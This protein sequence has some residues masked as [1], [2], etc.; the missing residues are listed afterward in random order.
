MIHTAHRTA[1][2]R[3][4]ASE[5]RYGPNTL[6]AYERDLDDFSSY[7][8]S[9]RIA[10]DEPLSRQL[11]RG[12]LAQM[13]SRKLARTT[14]ARR[15]SSLRSFYRFCGR[16][17]F[18]DVPDLGWLRA[19]KPPHAVPKSLSVD[20]A[21]AL[22]QAI[23]N[24]RGAD[25]IKKRDFAILI[26][27]YGA[28]LRISEALGLLRKD[29]PLGNW[30]RITGKGNK[31]RDVPVLKA[32]SEAVDDYLAECPIDNGP[33][34]ALF[35]SSRG[36]TLGARAVQRLIETLRIDLNLPAHVTP[37]SL[38]HAFATHLLGNGGDLRAIQELLG[39]ASLSTTQR[40]TH[41]DASHLI[42]VHRDTHPRAR[43]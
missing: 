18:F 3:W 22:L 41:V 15:V 30:L 16:N 7:F 11:F 14:I 20:D 6:D 25:W 28:G 42:Q 31:V 27:L 12:W 9:N 40:Y 32:A 4:L 8:I 10:K 19:P 43:R 23:F 24:Q 21:Q 35:L 26:L 38:R 13:A 29:A 17:Q 1:W 5:K 33:N 36:Q 2:L 34:A 37:H 39:H